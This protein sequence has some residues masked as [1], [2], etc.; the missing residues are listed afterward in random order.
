MAEEKGPC[1]HCGAVLP[2]AAMARQDHGGDWVYACADCAVA[3][4]TG[5]GPERGVAAGRRR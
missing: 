1:V 3:T 5:K 4:S 2:L